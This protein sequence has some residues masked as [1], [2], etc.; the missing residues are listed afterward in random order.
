M[1]ISNILQR[2]RISDKQLQEQRK[3]LLASYPNKAT[4]R[5]LIEQLND[6]ARYCYMC[7]SQG[8]CSLFMAICYFALG[9]YGKG[10]LRAEEAKQHF[11][12]VNNTWN[13]IHALELHG[14]ILINAQGNRHQAILTYQ[15]AIRTLQEQYIP[16]HDQDYDPQVEELQK[17][18]DLLISKGNPI[19]VSANLQLG[20]MP[21]YSGVQAS[22]FGPTWVELPLVV[23]PSIET[24]TFQGKSYSLFST[25]PGI[26]EIHVQSGKE[27]GW[28]EVFGDSMD[29]AK[30]VP[31]CEHDYVLFYKASTADHHQIV[32][33]AHPDSSKSGYQWMIK[34]YDQTNSQFLSETKA[35]HKHPPIA[36][37]PKDTILGIVIAVAKPL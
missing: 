9:E 3:H 12:N 21:V 37:R 26:R 27:Y 2:L 34:R 24:L 33:V 31:I 13:L 18:F 36:V 28:V 32:I 10:I 25:I 4:V 6:E 5:L 1:I 22:P 20:I 30:P 7:D 15:E 17:E 35:E 11:L 19:P 16:T 23:R 8:E 29:A 14:L